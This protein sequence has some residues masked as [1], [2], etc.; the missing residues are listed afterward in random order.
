[1][2]AYVERYLRTRPDIA[3]DM[4][5]LVRHLAPTAEG[6]PLEVYVF[7][8]DVR[9]AVYERV[10]ADVFDHL[11]AILPE[12]GLSVFQ[13]PSG[14]DLRALSATAAPAPGRPAAAATSGT[15]SA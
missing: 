2:R 8:A 13:A 5:F 9:W 6:L 15:A 10:Q 14:A 4:T 7:V 1:F 11:L 12:F 3:Q